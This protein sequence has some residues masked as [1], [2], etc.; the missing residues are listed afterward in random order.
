MN[1]LNRPAPREDS[2][3]WLSLVWVMLLLALISCVLMPGMALV[4]L[5]DNGCTVSETVDPSVPAASGAISLAQIILPLLCL[6]ALFVM[7]M[8][9]VAAYRRRSKIKI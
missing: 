4:L 6:V 7:G 3:I 2:R 9:L 5:L 1:E 8:S